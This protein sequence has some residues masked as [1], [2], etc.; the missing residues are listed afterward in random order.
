MSRVPLGQPTLMLRT[1]PPAIVLL[2]WPVHAEPTI[3][4]ESTCVSVMSAA[5][6]AIFLAASNIAIVRG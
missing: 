2:K 1:S 4:T 5:P 6:C 3:L